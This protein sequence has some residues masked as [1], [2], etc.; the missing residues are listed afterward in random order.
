VSKTLAPG[1]RLGWV[2]APTWLAGTL[3][4]A[5]F[6]NDTR[7]CRPVTSASFPCRVRPE[8]RAASGSGR[9]V[10]RGDARQIE[11]GIAAMAARIT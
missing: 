5:K 1:L 11:R 7:P 2:V 10:R 6:S 3:A 4:D 8:R 9:R